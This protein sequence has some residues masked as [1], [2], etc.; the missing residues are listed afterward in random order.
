MDASGG[1]PCLS[2]VFWPGHSVSSRETA[3]LS[4]ETMRGV[5]AAQA[6]HVGDKIDDWRDEQP[7]RMVHELHTSPLAVLNYNPHG[8]YFG[9]VTVKFLSRAGCRTVALDGRQRTDPAVPR[10]GAPGF[11]MGQQIHP[12]RK[13]IL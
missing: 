13:R 8:R 6:H 3:A 7:G 2:G 10:G 1:R 9:T 5:L 12:R 11:A 4:T